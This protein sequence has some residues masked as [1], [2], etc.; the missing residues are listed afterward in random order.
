MKQHV[1]LK[2]LYSF[3]AVAELGSMTLAAEHLFVSHS[4]VSQSVKSLESQLNTKLFHRVGR[5]VELTKEGKNYYRDVG[6]ALEQIVRASEAL[7]NKHRDERL[8]I[9]M[10]NSLALHWWIPRVEDLQKEIPSLDV[11]IS[12]L[13]GPFDLEREGVDVAIVHGNIEDW[14]DYYSEKLG[15]DELV[16]VCSPSIAKSHPKE[17]VEGLLKRYPSIWVT[18]DRRKHDWDLW[19]KAH[20]ISSPTTHGTLKFNA[21]VQAIHAAIRSLGILVTHRLFIKDEVENQFLIEI[22]SPVVNPHQEYHFA[23]LPERLK[24]ES[25]LALRRWLKKEFQVAS[26]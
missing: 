22:G 13:I 19:C 8:T 11:R 10:V 4:A 3:V 24:L 15:D 21:S 25:T 23:C 6:P 5:R 2:S 12:N 7:L 18:N 20:N 26:D 17:D 9:N 16:M 1:A 14:S